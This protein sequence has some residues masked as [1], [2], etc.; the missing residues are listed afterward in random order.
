MRPD[1]IYPKTLKYLSS[2]ESFTSVI[3]KLFEKCI[4]YEMIPYICKTAI[5]IPLHKKKVRYI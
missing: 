2:N 1:E 4:K 3:C 5:V